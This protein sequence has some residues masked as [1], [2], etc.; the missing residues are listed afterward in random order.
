MLLSG[1]VPA[2]EGTL[3]HDLTIVSKAFGPYSASASIEISIPQH[4]G[5]QNLS[6]GYSTLLDAFIGLPCGHNVS[7]H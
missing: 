1:T 5:S 6:L 2:R 4:L 3:P 7:N